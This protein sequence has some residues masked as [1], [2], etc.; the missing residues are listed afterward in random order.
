MKK[1]SLWFLVVLVYT[2]SIILQYLAYNGGEQTLFKYA[3]GVCVFCF[4]IMAII[5][6]DNLI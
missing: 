3:A 5:T 1:S 6:L 2:V 4:V